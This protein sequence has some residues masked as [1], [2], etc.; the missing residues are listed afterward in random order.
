MTEIDPIFTALTAP[1]A[2]FAIGERDGIRQFLNAPSDLNQMIER[3]RA[4]GDRTF[5]VEEGDDGRQRRLSF[6]QVFAWRDQLVSILGIARGD[7]VAICMRNRTE[8]IVAFLAVLKAGGVAA[9]LNSRGAPAE[10]VAMIDDVGPRVVVADTDRARLIRAG[11]L[12]SPA[13]PD[14][15]VRGRRSA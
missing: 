7:R 9:V 13:R 3:A 11:V 15:T 2:P 5:I 10:L 14:Q 6:E 1:G 8:W 12:G 4:F